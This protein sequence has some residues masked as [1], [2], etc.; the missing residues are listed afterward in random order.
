MASGALVAFPTETVYGLGAD[1]F[2]VAALARVFEAKKRPRFDP[3]IVHIAEM[4]ALYSVADTAALDARERL[5]LLAERFWP[6]PLTLILP[7]RK[8]VPELATAGLETVAVR[9]PAHPAAQKLIS[10]VKGNLASGGLFKGA[11]AAP[12][13]N[14]FGFLSPTRA[15]HVIEQL[16]E[17]VDFIIDG[18]RTQLGLESTVLDI[19][20]GL[21]MG[22]SQALPRILRPGGIPREEIE[23]LIGPLEQAGP[24]GENAERPL[25]PGQ[26]KSH[27]A[28]RTPLL[29][30]RRGELTALPPGPSE[31][32]L[33]FCAPGAPAGPNCRVLSESGNLIEAAAN[34]FD[35][36]HELDSLGLDL[37]RA[38]EV[39]EQG[40][41]TAINDRLRRASSHTLV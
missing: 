32:R 24:Q 37:I 27:Y 25:S 5:F 31:G 6:G 29:L 19:S 8:E 14:P 7:K 41:G 36:L 40:L 9:F 10:L 4:D 16:G 23:A 38:E 11:V 13:A 21:S 1:A 22:L 33:Y 17:K 20:M 35:M 39:P 30:C 28:P 26:L 12:S 2:N 15:E 34:L 18:G 3:L